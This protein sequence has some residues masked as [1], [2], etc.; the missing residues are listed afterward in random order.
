MWKLTKIKQKNHEKFILV[1]ILNVKPVGRV[2]LRCCESRQPDFPTRKDPDEEEC[3][4]FASQETCKQKK[5]KKKIIKRM[6]LD[7]KLKHSEKV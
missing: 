5:Q 6:L 4:N 7:Q 3:R 1:D 2:R